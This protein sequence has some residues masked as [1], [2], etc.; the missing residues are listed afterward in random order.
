MQILHI[1]LCSQEIS[2]SVNML[3]NVDSYGEFLATYRPSNTTPVATAFTIRENYISKLIY[4][5]H[6]CGRHKC[7][8]V[9]VMRWQECWVVHT[10][11]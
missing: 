4:I 6:V 9:Q 2:G 3:R 10:T 11:Q 1:S 5:V 8:V 7:H